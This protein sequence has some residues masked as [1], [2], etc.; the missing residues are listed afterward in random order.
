MQNR[1]LS[2][3]E[4]TTGFFNCSDLGTTKKA[5]CKYIEKR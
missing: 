2:L 1:K 4:K 5:Y 3:L